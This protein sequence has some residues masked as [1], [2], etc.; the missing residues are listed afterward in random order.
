[1]S[2]FKSLA[3]VLNAKSLGVF[4]IKNQP[5]R[6]TVRFTDSDGK[7]KFLDRKQISDG[8]GGTYWAWSVGKEVQQTKAPVAEGIAIA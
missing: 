8:K 3:D 7:R 6:F 1:M 5:G 2:E 4:P